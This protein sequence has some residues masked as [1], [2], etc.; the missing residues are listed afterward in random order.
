MEP[1]TRWRCETDVRCLTAGFAVLAIAAAS[2]G[3]A[4]SKP[5]TGVYLGSVGRPGCTPSATFTGGQPEAGFD[6]TKGSVW[7][8]FFHSVP[9][10]AGQDIKVVWRMTG[11][12][13]FRIA[14]RDA[15]GT[16]SKLVF[17]PEPHEGSSWNTH[18]G[19][20]VGTGFNFA[21]AGC[22][23]LNIART[24]TRADLWLAVI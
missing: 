22:W 11:S 19:A 16:A 13:D 18:P 21:H 7:A 4:P 6:S 5:A 17:G 23:D 10:P 3:S 1:D 15:A 12:G 2:C 8:L 14:A 20:E 24:D 9:P